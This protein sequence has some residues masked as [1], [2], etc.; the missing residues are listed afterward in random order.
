MIVDVDV[1]GATESR[2]FCCACLKWKIAY[3]DIGFFRVSDM[4]QPL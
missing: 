1:R 2:V 4:S 3:E